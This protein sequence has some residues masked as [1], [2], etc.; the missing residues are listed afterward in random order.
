M[1][2]F[3]ILH[4]EMPPRG[5]R[6]THWDLLL[7]HGDV[8]RAWALT[9]PPGADRV[10]AAQQLPD[11]RLLYL[12][13]EGP[14]S[15]NRG[16]VTQWDAGTCRWL[17]EREDTVSVHLHGRRLDGQIDLKRTG[18]SEESWQVVYRPTAEG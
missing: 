9:E 8:L 13:Y 16:R 4:H 14:V 11:H 2:R 12:D 17:A 15:R 10:I 6:P 5:P 3:A 18:Q 7:Q 1:S